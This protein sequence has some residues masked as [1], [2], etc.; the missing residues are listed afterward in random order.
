MKAIDLR[1]SNPVV[2]PSNSGVGSRFGPIAL[3]IA[4]AFVF[5]LILSNREIPAALDDESYLTYAEVSRE[6]LDQKLQDSVIAFAFGEPLWLLINSSLTFFFDEELVVRIIIFCS[7]LAAFI[8]VARLVHWSAVL[9]AAFFLLPMALTPHVTHLRQG[10]AIALF[11]MFFAFAQKRLLFGTLLAAA[12]HS[13]FIPLFI[14]FSA[15]RIMVFREIFARASKWKLF[16][17]WICLVFITPILLREILG[18]VGDRRIDEYGYGIEKSATGLGFGLWAIFGVVL[19]FGRE[20]VGNFHG[21]IAIAIVTIY[22]GWY[23]FI[24]I[25]SRLLVAA[26]IFVWLA[27]NELKAVYRKVFFALWAMAS[28]YAWMNQMDKS[29]LYGF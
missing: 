4:L 6:I 14:L 25:G 3:C 28:A 24:E 20:G 26:L 18:W 8:S 23:F 17:V 19:Y 11:L 9:C 1:A 13:S 21:R 29:Y 22:L 12:I 10:T 7:A 15:D 2:N 5:A 16:V 27:G